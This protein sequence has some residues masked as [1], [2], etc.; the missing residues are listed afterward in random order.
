MQHGSAAHASQVAAQHSNAGNAMR[1][2]MATMTAVLLVPP[3][4]VVVLRLR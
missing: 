3:A 4:V 2:N 1:L